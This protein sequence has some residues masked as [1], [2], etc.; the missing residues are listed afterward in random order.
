MSGTRHTSGKRSFSYSL[1]E[2]LK[3]RYQLDNVHIGA[4]HESKCVV[5]T[6]QHTVFNWVLVYL[7]LCIVKYLHV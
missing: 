4:V 3:L 1:C 2:L 6:T 7:L 5:N